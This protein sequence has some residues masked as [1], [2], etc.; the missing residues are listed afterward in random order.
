M[1]LNNVIILNRR[2]LKEFFSFAEFW[3]KRKEFVD[4]SNSNLFCK[5]NESSQKKILNSLVRDWIKGRTLTSDKGLDSHCI[6]L[7]SGKITRRYTSQCEKELALLS[8][9][10]AFGIVCLYELMERELRQDIYEVLSYLGYEIFDPTSGVITLQNKSEREFEQYDEQ[11]GCKDTSVKLC[12]VLIANTSKEQYGFASVRLGS[13]QI[14]IQA[15][16][17]IRAIFYGKKCL[18]LL[19]IV[20]SNM[21]F[22][23]NKET[24][25]TGASKDGTLLKTVGNVLAFTCGNKGYIYSTDATDKKFV[26]S[27]YDFSSEDYN[28][29]SNIGKDETIIYVEMD[30]NEKKCLFLTDKKNLYLYDTN[31][32]DEI[33]L[34]EQNVLMA[35]FVNNELQTIKL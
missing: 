9:E 14:N 3:K 13:K 10:E 31:E 11:E 21:K 25:V 7:S 23:F 16:E 34:H 33:V 17:C 27:H 19:P 22:V 35:S 1:K 6:M 2:H 18:K 29:T 30:K 24:Y 5:P 28:V 26:A 8:R 4:I 32:G 15:G 12:N 20:S